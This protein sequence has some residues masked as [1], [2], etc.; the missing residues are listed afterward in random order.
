MESTTNET[1]DYTMFGLSK[2]APGESGFAAA[3]VA[4]G[5][6][7]GVLLLGGVECASLPVPRCCE[8]CVGLYW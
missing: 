2:E 8:G 1:K 6:V 7:S 3:G 4:V 5:G